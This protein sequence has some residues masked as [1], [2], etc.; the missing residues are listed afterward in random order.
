[1][2]AASHSYMLCRPMCAAANA[3]EHE[4]SIIAFG[5]INPK[6]YEVRPAAILPT[7]DVEA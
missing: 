2:R 3:E 5:P 6:M 1:M 4:V 7:V